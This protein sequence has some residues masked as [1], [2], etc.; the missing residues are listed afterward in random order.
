MT[1]RA[2]ARLARAEGRPQKA[3]GLACDG[4]LAALSAG[5]VLLS[6]D[7]LEVIVTLCFDLGHC[8]VAARLLGAA[9]RQRELNWVRPVGPG[10]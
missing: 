3:L 8:E 1:L 9:D 7:L 5:A 4:L 2:A 10:L 6:V